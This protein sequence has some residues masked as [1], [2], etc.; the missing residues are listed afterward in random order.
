MT[1]AQL[2]DYLS[3][4]RPGDPE[5]DGC[6]TGKIYSDMREQIVISLEASKNYLKL[7]K[8]SFEIFGYDFLIDNNLGTWLVEVNTNPCYDE[9][10]SILK[11]FIPRMMNDALKLT[12][13]ICFGTKKGMPA[14]K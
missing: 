14:Y 5:V 12:I 11:M 2:Q 7:E 13:D 4:A 10:S 9:P 6:V 8:G 1:F 3:E